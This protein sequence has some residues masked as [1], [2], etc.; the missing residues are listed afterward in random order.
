M[1]ALAAARFCP[2]S[3]RSAGLCAHSGASEVGARRRRA[4]GVDTCPGRS[5]RTGRTWTSVRDDDRGSRASAHRSKWWCA[6]QLSSH[7]GR[8]SDR[9]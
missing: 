5:T 6:V 3:S 2:Q 4:A 8:R 9:I 1:S 7:S